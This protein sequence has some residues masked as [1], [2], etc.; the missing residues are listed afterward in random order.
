MKTNKWSGRRAGIYPIILICV[1]IYLS[2]ACRS[3]VPVGRDY[4]WAEKDDIEAVKDRLYNPQLYGE[5]KKKAAQQTLYTVLYTV[6][7]LLAP[8]SPHITEEIY[9]AM[10][11]EDKGFKSIHLSSW[12]TVDKS[13]LIDEIEQQG[14][15]IMAVISEI[16]REKA[17]KRLPLNTQISKLTI[18][19]GGKGKAETSN[20]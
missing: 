11:A 14:D 4:T 12:P 1:V 15:L 7:Q 2:I 6:L 13:R 20:R 16:R 18:Y 17:E 8:I 19:S 10:Y 3:G 9:Q 5:E